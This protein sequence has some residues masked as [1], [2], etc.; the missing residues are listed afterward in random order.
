MERLLDLAADRLHIDRLEIRRRNLIG[1]DQLPY[2]TA[3]GLTYDSGDFHG[4]MAAALARA[5]WKSFPQRRKASRRAGRLRGIGIANYIEAP[6]GAPYERVQLSVRPEGQVENDLSATQSSGPGPRDRVRASRRRSARRAARERQAQERRHQ[7]G[8]EGRRHPFGALDAAR[9]HAPGRGL[10]KDPG[11]GPRGGGCRACSP[12]DR[13]QIFGWALHCPELQPDFQPVRPR[14]PQ[15]ARHAVG[16]GRAL[17]PDSG[18]SDRL[19]HLRARGRSA[20]RRGRDQTLHVGGRRRRADQSHAG[21]W[22][23]AWRHRAGHRPGAVGRSRGR[24]RQRAGRQRLVHGLRPVAGRRRAALRRRARARSDRRQS[25]RHQGRRRRRH[26]AGAG[27]GDQRARRRAQG[28]TAS[29]TSTC[30]PRR[31]GSGAQS[32][33]RSK[34]GSISASYEKQGFD[35]EK[36]R[37]FSLNL[38]LQGGGRPATRVGWGSRHKRR[39]RGKTRPPPGAPISGLPEIGIM[40]RKSSKL[41]LRGATLPLSGGGKRHRRAKQRNSNAIALPLQ[42]EVTKEPSPHQNLRHSSMVSTMG[43]LS[44]PACPWI[45]R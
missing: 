5:E 44:H 29:T 14:G 27:R 18:P 11:Q 26:H 37:R 15:R 1:K 28:I 19:R 31:C 39:V 21:R 33:P 35:P 25:A 10:R 3:M 45:L 13:D 42:R 32:R 8:R 17:P 24:S 36:R 7:R 4:N 12:G 22:A 38:P 40:G 23:D 2:R 34:A 41:D 30:R 9:R 16:H 20:N 6:V 43:L